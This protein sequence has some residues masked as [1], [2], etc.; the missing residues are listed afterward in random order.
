[1]E[2]G[3]GMA[4]SVEDEPGA[5]VF[6][7]DR[8]GPALERR[9]RCL[10][11]AGIIFTIATEHRPSGTYYKLRV[12]E[13]D[14]VAAHLALQMG[15]CARSSRLRDSQPSLVAGLRDFARTLWDEAMLLLGR[16][17][18]LVRLPFPRL[19]TGPTDARTSR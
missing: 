4:R 11:L 9:Q 2:T 17:R 14:A 8:Q 16:V 6:V 13:R 19:L 1:M 12:R 10:R 3:G 15:G 18:D 5:V 7:C